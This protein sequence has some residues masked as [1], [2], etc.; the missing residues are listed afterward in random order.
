MEI[1]CP[2]C[3]KKYSYDRKICQE[4]EDTS[5]YSSGAD[6]INELEHKWNC[7]I[8]LDFK[9]IAFKPSKFCDLTREL[10]PE[11]NNLAIYEREPYNWNCDPSY[12]LFRKKEKPSTML[13]IGDFSI[14]MRS[15]SNSHLFYE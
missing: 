13:T 3:G 11:P 1:K 2:I 6:F 12:Q 9:S 5:I 4:C 7:S 8:F 10:S 14:H 15:K